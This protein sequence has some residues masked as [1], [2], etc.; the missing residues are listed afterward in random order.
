MASPNHKK[1]DDALLLAIA[2]GATVENAA[3][4]IGLHERT[5]YRRI[6]SPDFQRKLRVLRADMLGRTSAALTAAATE[7]VRT[8]LDLQKP[9][10]QA[11]V[12]LGAARAILEIGAK[13]RETVE[14][15]ARIAA[16]EDRA[17]TPILP[18]PAAA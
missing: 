18:S 3:R 7:A 4:Q 17:L 5:V 9:G 15:E 10:V 16:L 11:A 8:L 12:R 1:A 6:K 14:L 13:V 2:C